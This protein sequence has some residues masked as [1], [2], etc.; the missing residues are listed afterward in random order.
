MT[1]CD[2]AALLLEHDPYDEAALRVLLRAYV[3]GGQTAAAL[4]AYA[5]ARERLADDLGTDPSA[6]TAAL[7]L[8]IL[9]GELPAAAAVPVSDAITLVGRDNELTFLDATALQARDGRRRTRRHR[10]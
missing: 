2:A 5:T 7:H 6:E 8:A 1:A 9:R 10:G 3:F 4:D